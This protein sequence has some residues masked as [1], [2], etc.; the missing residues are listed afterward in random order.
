[1]KKLLPVIIGILLFSMAV[2]PQAMVKKTQ[3][4][5]PF[6]MKRIKVIRPNGGEEWTVGKSYQVR[7]EERG[8]IGDVKHILFAYPS[9]P[10]WLLGT[11]KANQKNLKYYHLIL[12]KFAGYGKYKI[13]VISTDGRVQDVSDKPFYI[14]KWP[15]RKQMVKIKLI[16]FIYPRTQDRICWT[17]GREY[18]MRIQLRGQ[19]S[20]KLA[21]KLTGPGGTIELPH[22]TANAPGV[23]R[24]PI[25]VPATFAEGRYILSAYNVDKPEDEGISKILARKKC[26]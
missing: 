24:Q 19:G 2:W 14:K 4:K 6:K 12:N 25:I 11:V 5:T 7:W 3:S 21:I 13:Q 17:L 10:Q 20:I 26:R 23:V 8:Y 16:A 15:M 1:M 18:T 9:G 22:V